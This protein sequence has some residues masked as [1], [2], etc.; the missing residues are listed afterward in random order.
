MSGFVRESLDGVVSR[1]GW[2]SLPEAQLALV[3]S[4]PLPVYLAMKALEPR[5]VYLLPTDQTQETARRI[6]TALRSS[7]PAT[8][9]RV[10][11]SI[12]ESPGRDEIR[13]RFGEIPQRSFGL[14]YTG[15][16]KQMAVRVYDVWRQHVGRDSASRLHWA[17][18]LQ[19]RTFRL[20]LDRDD[21]Y[22]ALWPGLQLTLDEIVTLHGVGSSKERPRTPQGWVEARLAT[23]RLAE[24]RGQKVPQ[25][26]GESETW[27]FSNP[28]WEPFRAEVG[29]GTD[30][31]T[32]GQYVASFAARETSGS[33]G[34]SGFRDAK[35]WLTGG[36]LEDWTALA[37]TRAL[38]RLG[39][40]TGPHVVKVGWTL[41]APKARTRANDP[42]FEV[43]V[44]FVVGP[45]PFVISCSTSKDQSAV[46]GKLFEVDKRAMQLGG[47]CAQYAVVSL[48]S[49][50][51]CR[52]VQKDVSPSWARVNLPIVFDA[53]QVLDPDRLEN[54]IEQWVRQV[55]KI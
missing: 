28:V 45:A 3:G 1:N 50:E 14:H 25:P 35:T 53:D 31:L 44:V 4:N 30:P 6:E 22:G 12:E 38:T 26:D 21:R 39:L 13:A 54:A 19:A 46:K 11:G 36:W 34:A 49:V 5:Y 33:A 16:T 20:L 17:S 10:L 24:D 7:M 42:S 47:D 23:Q 18:Y 41:E 48:A 51:A 32:V 2:E 27:E 37:V 8:Q 29:A 55:M 52:R 40:E 9:V 15:G 43:D